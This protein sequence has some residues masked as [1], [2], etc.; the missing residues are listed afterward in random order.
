MYCSLLQAR[1]RSRSPREVE[2]GGD[3]GGGVSGLGFYL[4]GHVE[5]PMGFERE[6]E[7]TFGNQITVVWKMD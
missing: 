5:S 4:V 3:W 1:K 7:S 6:N 2:G